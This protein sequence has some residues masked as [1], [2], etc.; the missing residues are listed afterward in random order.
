MPRVRISNAREDREIDHPDGPIEFGRGPGRAGVPRVVIQ[1]QTV[2][3]DHFRLTPLGPDRVRIENLSQKYPFGL[4]TGEVV[5]PGGTIEASLPVSLI[6]GETL[7]RIEPADEPEPLSSMD[8]LSRPAAAGG[9]RPDL[10]L[11]TLGLAPPAASLAQW[12][13]SLIAVQRAAPGSPEFFAQT[14]RAMVDLIGLDRGLVLLGAGPP[15]QVA[16]RHARPDGDDLPGREFSTTILRQVCE[17]R[18]TFFNGNVGGAL[19]TE[20]LVH[21]AAVVASPILAA[22]GQVRGV[23]YGCRAGRAGR[24][25]V[26]MG[27]IGEV[28]AHAVQLLA[29]TAGVGLDRLDEEARAN[30]LRVAVEAA[31]E[32]DRAKSQFLALMSHE[33]R[34]PLTAILGYSEM[35]VEQARDDGQGEMIPDLENIHTA[36]RHLLTLIND[37]LDLSKIEAGKM[38]VSPLA[39]D[40]NGAVNE[41]CRTIRPLAAK[42]ANEFVADVP[43]GLGMVVQDPTRIR[44]CLL[45]L[46]SNACKFTREGVVT[47]QVSRYPA[48]GGDRLLMRVSDTGIGMTP[49]QLA[50][51]FQPFHQADAS[52][53]RKYGGTGL[54]LT[55]CRKLCRM[56]GGDVT[57]ESEP[58]KGSAFTIDLS[59]DS[60]GP[61]G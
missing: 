23:L 15:W 34:T 50:S 7:V 17:N 47:L 48:D 42:N 33:L 12:F 21:V 11:V 24:R 46:L 16:A 54:G 3:R 26:A 19:A 2:S 55:I 51:L 52:I 35:L 38:A 30:R 53:T 25:G 18:R 31:E 37:I 4:N 59:A 20:S 28:E 60:P 29:T 13:E 44:Q 36:G 49:E 41:V 14:A 9:S 22:D 6:A 57:A 1:D 45:N 10:S 56:M 8:T 40:L 5:A 39:F 32:A 43:A 61:G 27:G 58:G